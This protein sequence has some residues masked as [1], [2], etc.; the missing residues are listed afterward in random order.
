MYHDAPV[1]L[2]ASVTSV[3]MSLRQRDERVTYINEIVW[4]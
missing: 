2:V 3:S 4:I 1:L